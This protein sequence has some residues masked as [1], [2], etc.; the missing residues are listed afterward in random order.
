MKGK[1]Q[2]IKGE[3]CSTKEDFHS[4]RGKIK[5]QNKEK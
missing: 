3:N 4:K 2:T 5:S 1:V